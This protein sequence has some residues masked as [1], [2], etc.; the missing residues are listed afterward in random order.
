MEYEEVSMNKKRYIGI[1][2]ITLIL[3]FFVST[4]ISLRSVNILMDDNHEHQANIYATDICNELHEFLLEPRLIAQSMSNELANNIVIKKDKYTDQKLSNVIGEYLDEIVQKFEFDTAYFVD[5]SN[6]RYYSVDGYVK[7]LD[8]V[9]NESDR[10]YSDFTTSGIP[11]SLNI[12]NDVVDNDKVMV[13]VNC[14]VED[15]VGRFIGVCGIG[16][17]KEHINELVQNFENKYNLK[18][19][20]VSAK[21]FHILQEHDKEERDD[22]KEIE[23]KRMLRIH[24]PQQDY[25]FEM[26]DDGG[27]LIS[28]QIKECNWFLVVEESGQS[29]NIYDNLLTWNVVGC[30][31]I[32]ILVIL[33]FSIIINHMDKCNVS[34]RENEEEQRDIIQSLADIYST[35]HMFD[36]ENGVCREIATNDVMRKVVLDNQGKDIQ[37]IIHNAMRVTTQSDDLQ[38][39]LEFTDFFT[40]PERMSGHKIISQEFFGGKI[41]WARASFI[42]V[43]E[44]EN[45]RVSKVLFVTQ[46]IDDDKKR[47][48]QLIRISRT[49]ELTRAYNRRAYDEA[50]EK[51]KQIHSQDLVIVSVDVNGL[52]QVNDKLG[53][54][55]GDELILGATECLRS[56]FAGY[57]EIYR[58]GGDEFMVLLHC[59]QEQLEKM[60]VKLEKKVQSWSGTKVSQ[61]AIAKGIVMCNQYQ[62]QTIE[63]LEKIADQL[64]YDD[65]TRYYQ[66]MGI[67]RRRH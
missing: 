12:K 41:G 61:L 46:V 28:K 55:A 50:I 24:N 31:I 36:L 32:L 22:K 3:S 52:K 11:Y 10:W 29:N 4:L 47:E 60:V 40:L 57:G 20:I 67:E 62:D 33:I 64:M 56:A 21:G 66:R 59:S 30:I 19:H 14:R 13:F 9:N 23:I 65:K 34:I 54:V 51:E 48:E 17:R 16:V 35:M 38:S 44:D 26:T 15:T 63:E 49:D 18:I 5:G 58:T 37:T 25:K 27:F 39:M 43:Q 7:T 53:H 42:R 45:Q 2:T 8:Y 1:V 6:N